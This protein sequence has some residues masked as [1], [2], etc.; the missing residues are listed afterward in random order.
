M[1]DWEVFREAALA[2]LDGRN[3]YSVG[4]GEMLFFNPVWTL[5]PLIPLALLPLWYGLIANALVSTTALL[6]VSRYLELGP[7]GFF[8]VAVS[9]MHIQSMIYGNIEW[10][11][12]LG[13]LFPP[14]IALIFF[15]TK[16]QSTVGLIVLLLWRECKARQWQ[17][18]VRT[19]APALVLAICAVL[20]YGF[21]SVPS[22]QNPGQRSLFPFSLLVGVPVLIYAIRHQDERRAMFVGP[23][24]APYVTFHGYLP[25]LFALEG[26]WMVLGVLVS[27]IP[28]VLGLVY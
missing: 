5:L 4:E 13:L 27:F 1:F 26:K 22:G 9:P 3:P 23:F 8:L 19:M 2:L 7:W 24:V 28:V 18:V 16:P 10:L 11:P 20:I 25:A 17:G 14:P 21:P 6:F 12:L 15:L